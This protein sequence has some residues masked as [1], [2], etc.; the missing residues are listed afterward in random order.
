MIKAIKQDNIV[1]CVSV[2][3]DSFITVAKEFGI[4]E[5]NAPRFT[6]F[7]TDANRIDWHLNEEHRPMYGFWEKGKLVGYYSLLLKDNQECELNNLCVLPDYR[8]KKI[9]HQLLEHSFQQAK[10][11]NCIK[12]NIGI[13]EENRVLR[14]WYESYGFVY[15][16]SE[17][18]DFFP[19][20][21]GYLVKDFI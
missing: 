12:M 5:Q 14:K 18:Y 9:G 15:M 2:I 20:A 6:A 8:H 11:R 1:D 21:C 7:A 4:T 10:K 19:F 3:R 13:V 16:K 17:K